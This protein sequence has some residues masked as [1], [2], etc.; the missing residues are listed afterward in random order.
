MFFKVTPIIFSTTYFCDKYEDQ[1]AKHLE[2]SEKCRLCS[3]R[4]DIKFSGNFVGGQGA[5]SIK[6]ANLFKNTKECGFVPLLMYNLRSC[7][8]VQLLWS[9]VIKPAQATTK[10][11][12]RNHLTLKTAAYEFCLPFSVTRLGDFLHFGQPFKSGGYNYFSQI[13]HIVRQIL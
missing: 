7:P 9:N 5:A 11:C 13:A 6:T 4:T 12:Q 2:F 3:H 1:R 10:S 8:K